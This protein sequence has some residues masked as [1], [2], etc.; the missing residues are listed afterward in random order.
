M[1]FGDYFTGIQRSLET[2]LLVGRVRLFPLY[3]RAKCCRNRSGL[4]KRWVQAAVSFSGLHRGGGFV[5]NV[6]SLFI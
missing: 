1:P 6:L 3:R 2:G 4:I 5:F